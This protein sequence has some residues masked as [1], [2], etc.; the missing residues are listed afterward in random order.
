MNKDIIS[1]QNVSSIMMF[2]DVTTDI[3]QKINSKNMNM[4]DIGK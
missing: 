4:L 3:E 1:I 2:N